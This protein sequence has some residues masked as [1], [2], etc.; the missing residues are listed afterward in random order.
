MRLLFLLMAS[1]AIRVDP[2]A[3]ELIG[4][5]VIGHPADIVK[6]IIKHRVVDPLSYRPIAVGEKILEDVGLKEFRF[7]II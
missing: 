3:R 2:K 1:L 6:G 5:S 4:K 7:T